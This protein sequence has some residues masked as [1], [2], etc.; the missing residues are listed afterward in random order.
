MSRILISSA[1]AQHQPID[2]S[3]NP[4]RPRKV[5]QSKGHVSP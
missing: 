2:T 5:D 1:G 3:W 4:G